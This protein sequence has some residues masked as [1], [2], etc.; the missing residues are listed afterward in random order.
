MTPWPKQA[1]VPAPVAHGCAQGAGAARPLNAVVVEPAQARDFLAPLPV[2]L[3]RTRPELQAL[4]E[5]LER[6][7]IRTLGEFAALPS[8]AVGERFGHPG[9]L[10]LD[11]AELT[12]G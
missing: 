11:L 5:V 1:A 12:Y 3:L 7:G 4:P 6:L 2:G 8:R 10:A 9:L